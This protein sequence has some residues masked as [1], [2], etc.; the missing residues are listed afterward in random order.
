MGTALRL[1]REQILAHRRRAGRLDE[2][3]RGGAAS[4]RR[5]AWVGLQDSVPR[6]AAHS[7]HARVAGVDAGV[8]ADPSLAQVWGPRF[9]AYVVPERDVALFTLMRLPDEGSRRERAETTADRLCAH[10]EGRRMTYSE[11]GKAL[12]MDPNGLRY[13][14]PTG[15]IR[16]RWDGAGRPEIW[17]V[18][19]PEVSSGVA[20]REMARRY[21][22]VLGPS[23]PERF[24]GWAGIPDSRGRAA[25]EALRR[26]IMTVITP[27]GEAWALGVDEE[28]LRA[29]S[30]AETGARLLP[31]GDAYF[32]LWGDDRKLLVPDAKR[33]G[34]L[35]TSRV[36]PGAV[37]VDGEVVGVWRRSGGL[38]TVDPWQRLTAAGK[39]AVEHEA[40]TLPLP[41]PDVPVE[42]TWS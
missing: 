41:E 9:T 16:I 34:S 1:D 30:G 21:L 38:V 15:R 37:L 8:W 7:L 23:T 2:R 24:A 39:R 13:A 5:A 18:P 31:S 33:R 4:L 14:A 36:W 25:F 10:L 12:G 3:M 42:V 22:H 11:A 19:A 26:S 28:S 35:W 17:C 32:L 40:A 27:I 29:G 20:L 6:S